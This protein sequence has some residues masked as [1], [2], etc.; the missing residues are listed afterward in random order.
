MQKGTKEFLKFDDV[1]IE[2][3]KFHS[4]QKIMIIKEAIIENN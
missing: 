2:K 4:S 3:K 1:E